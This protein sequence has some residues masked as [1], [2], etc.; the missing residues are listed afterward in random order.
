MFILP[1]Y[2]GQ[3][4]R[5]NAE[6]I[7]NVLAWTGL[8]QLLL[9]PLVPLLMKRFDARYIAAFGIALF[10]ISSFM[11]LTLSPDSAGDQL[12]M[13][14]IV[15]AIGQAL[16]ITP[17]SS[18]TTGGIA[19]SE[20]GAAS[21]LSNMLRNLGGAV[22]TATL[23]TVLTKREQFHSNII[24]ESVTLYRDE[25]RDRITALTNYFLSHGIS[26]PAT[27]KHQAIV[28]IGN[29]VKRQALII[30]FSDTFAV[31]G[32]VL[33]IAAIALLFARKVKTGSGAG[34]H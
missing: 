28:A 12:L 14:N 4:Q 23:A 17:L 29:L 20:A 27:A 26:D 34:A 15:R 32:F 9:I 25:V 3:V 7:G 10:A 1:Q 24:G 6:Q 21:G 33:D 16:I 22:G 2:L 18:I 31:I 11:N 13:P 19:P 8:P 5:Y 30:G